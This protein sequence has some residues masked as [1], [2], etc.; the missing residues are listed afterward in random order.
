[1]CA[2]SLADE[3]T[4]RPEAFGIRLLCDDPSVPQGSA[5]LAVRAA[6]AYLES[7]RRRLERPLGVALE[8]RK[9]IPMQAGMGGGSSD[10]AGVLA[11][12]DAMLGGLLGPSDLRALAL[13]LGAD[14][15]FFLGPSGAELIEGIGGPGIPITVRPFWAAVVKP[16]FGV[17][18]KWAYQHCTPCA[19][20]EGVNQLLAALETGDLKTAGQLMRN[21]LE[22]PVINQYPELAAVRRQLLEAGALG[23]MMTGSG[24]AVFGLAESREAAE[25]LAS[26]V[27]TPDRLTFV[28]CST[29]PALEVYSE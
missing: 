6:Q 23:A 25:R 9:H 27:S 26:A 16:A 10:A 20:A 11:G 15:P 1:M 3:I 8:L 14:V 21:D 17:S 5:N 19:E 12:L 13:P 22:L 29:A 24:S 2:V 7:A 4:L 18:T 28:V